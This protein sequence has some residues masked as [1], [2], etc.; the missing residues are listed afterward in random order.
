MKLLSTLLALLAPT[1]FFYYLLTG[2]EPGGYIQWNEIDPASASVD[3][4][5]LSAGKARATQDMLDFMT[6]P[7]VARS[8]A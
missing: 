5:A 4:S 1:Q 2:L 7:E 8:M 6:S 3:H